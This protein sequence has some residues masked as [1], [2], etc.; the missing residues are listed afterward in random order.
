MRVVD[1]VFD[2]SGLFDDR[3]VGLVLMTEWW[4]WNWMT[5]GCDVRVECV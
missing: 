3:M 5:G 1:V 2:E 4:W